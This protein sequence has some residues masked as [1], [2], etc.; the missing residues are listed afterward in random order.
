MILPTEL[1][2]ELATLKLD[3]A[4]EGQHKIKSYI[5]SYSHLFFNHC[6]NTMKLVSAW[7]KLGI[8]CSAALTVMADA[9]DVHRS[10]GTCAVAS[11]TG[12]GPY[13]T[14]LP[15]PVD[16][17]CDSTT[18][19]FVCDMAYANALYSAGKNCSSDPTSNCFC[20]NGTQPYWTCE[21]KAVV[22]DAGASLGLCTYN[23]TRSYEGSCSENTQPYCKLGTCG[24]NTDKQI[25]NVT[26]NLCYSG[27]PYVSNFCNTQRNIAKFTADRTCDPN[28]TN[29]KCAW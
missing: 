9:T 12:G 4:R 16:N 3:D 25:F 22:D 23:A 5:L 18:L 2:T 28:Y 1:E 13:I 21:S 6:T 8:L 11:C 29:S 14:T 24:G 15:G 20:S 19:A 7:I 26:G 27:S 17:P 10:L